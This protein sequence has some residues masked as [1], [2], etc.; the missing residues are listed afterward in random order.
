MA[1]LRKKQTDKGN[2]EYWTKG[3]RAKNSR[4]VK[5]I[6]PTTKGKYRSMLEAFIAEQ[7]DE[8][9]IEYS[10][11]TVILRYDQR[12]HNSRCTSC[13]HTGVV[14]QR[15]Y[16]GDFF[17]GDKVILEGK[18][19]LTASERTKLLAIRE[20]NPEWTI[21]LIFD[22]DNWITRNHKSRY[23][24]WARKNNFQYT[25]N[26]ELPDDILVLSRRHS[27]SDGD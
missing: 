10:Y 4:Q 18:G 1:K 17:V 11:E 22:K 20:S 3:R 26:G 6:R 13:G 2:A 9:G 7:L 16:T 8:R 14:K 25:L 23:S 21:V 24:D 15:T 12:V 5:K 27:P 19:K